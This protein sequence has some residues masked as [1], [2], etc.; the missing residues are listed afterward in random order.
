MRLVDV[1]HNRLGAATRQLA[2]EMT[3]GMDPTAVAEEAATLAGDLRRLG[4]VDGVTADTRDQLCALAER[5]AALGRVGIPPR[6]HQFIASAQ[7]LLHRDDLGRNGF[8]APERGGIDVP[9]QYRGLEPTLVAELSRVRTDLDALE[10]EIVD[11]LMAQGYFLT[12]LFIKLTMPE[13]IFPDHGPRDWYDERLSPRWQ[14]AHESVAAANANQATVAARL[15]HAARRVG[16]LGRVPGKIDRWRYRGI[17]MLV[18]TPV[19]LAVIATFMVFAVGIR[20]I[21]SWALR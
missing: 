19:M 5:A 4:D 2:H 17:L 3:H 11:L 13:L 15:Q 18:G 8:S 21:V 10:P 1:V 20:T 14:I 6:G 16:L 12:D 7:I 9:E